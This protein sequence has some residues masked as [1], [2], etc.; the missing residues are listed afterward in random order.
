[1]TINLWSSCPHIPISG[2][3]A[4]GT[5]PSFIYRELNLGKCSNS[6]AMSPAPGAVLNVLINYVCRRNLFFLY[7]ILATFEVPPPLPQA[8][9]VLKRMLPLGS[10]HRQGKGTGGM[11]S[12][13]RKVLACCCPCRSA[14]C[15]CRHHCSPK[16]VFL[17]SR[18]A[19]L[20]HNW[21]IFLFFET[22]VYVPDHV[23]CTGV[24]HTEY[25]IEVNSSVCSLRETAFS[26]LNIILMM[27]CKVIFPASSVN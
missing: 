8:Q 6:W 11:S 20:V 25:F 7:L 10:G 13:A 21:I 24:R 23:K 18:L 19:V 2:L 1:M 17:R 16:G 3:Q 12:R 5:T 22:T 15:S 27:N 4:C 26:Y 9:V 14:G